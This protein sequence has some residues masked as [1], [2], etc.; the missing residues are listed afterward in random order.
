MEDVFLLASVGAI[1]WILI[2]SRWVMSIILVWGYRFELWIR[3]KFVP[4]Q[5]NI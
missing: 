1:W 5:T 2:L 4:L 3:N